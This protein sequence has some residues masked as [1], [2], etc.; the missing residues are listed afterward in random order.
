MKKKKSL[1]IFSGGQDSTT[2]L[3]Y[4]KNKYEKVYAITF[5]YGQRHGQEINVAVNLTKIIGIKKHKIIDIS[6]L[7]KLFL[8]SLTNKNIF[9]EEKKSLN[10]NKTF[11]PGRNILFLVLS[12][13]Y[14]YNNNIQDI[15]IGVNQVDFSGYPDCRSNFIKSMNKTIKLGM[16]SSFSLKMPLINLNKSEIWA[17]SDFYNQSSLIFSSTL[18]CYNGIIGK[19]CF[20]CKACKIRNLGYKNWKLNK[21]LFMKSL[22]LKIKL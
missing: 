1:V 10:T 7:N 14:A 22:K 16:N 13:I 12:S 17:L 21:N 5:N 15:I 2:C 3:I 8:S 11:V 20:Q 6:N 19:G 9:F 4:A 18:T